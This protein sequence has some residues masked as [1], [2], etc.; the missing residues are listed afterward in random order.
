MIRVD[1]VHFLRLV[2]R[3]KD[4]KTI[5]YKQ[6]IITVYQNCNVILM[7]VLANGFIYIWHCSHLQLVAN[8]M[9][10]NICLQS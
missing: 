9:D 10:S 4:L 6:L 1:N 8:Q 5:P 7:T 2:N 3:I